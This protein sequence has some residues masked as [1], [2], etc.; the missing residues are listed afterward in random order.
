MTLR[1]NRSCYV[2]GETIFINAEINNNSR[3]DIENTHASLKQVCLVGFVHFTL[4]IVAH[5]GTS[6]Q[7]FCCVSKRVVICLSTSR[8]GGGSL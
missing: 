2:P 8:G 3:T 6:S 4:Q 5:F 1:L 7:L